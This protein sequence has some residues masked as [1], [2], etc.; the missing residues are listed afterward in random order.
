MKVKIY[1]AEGSKGNLQWNEWK[2]IDIKEVNSHL[3]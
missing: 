2:G 1:I 3:S